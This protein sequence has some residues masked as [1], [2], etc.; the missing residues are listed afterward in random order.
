MTP[1]PPTTH[2]VP[3]GSFP[4]GEGGV[5]VGGTGEGS[6]GTGVVVVGVTELQSPQ[7]VRTAA[8][9]ARKLDARLV[10]AWVDTSRHTLEVE[11]DGTIT[12]VTL[13]ADLSTDRPLVVPDGLNRRL[14][15]LLSDTGLSWS[16]VALAG[17]V[18]HELGSLADELDA[19]LLVVGAHEPSWRGSMRDFFLGS[20]AAQLAHRQ[21]RP[22]LVVPHETGR[23]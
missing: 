8:E 16:A 11:P 4:L 6:T 15:A 1:E 5:G 2:G 9:F 7:V 20:A 21:R 13:D 19:A 12:T 14:T 22:V 3:E 17:G 10:C 23:R 18:S